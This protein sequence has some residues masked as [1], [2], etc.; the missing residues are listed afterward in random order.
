MV[1]YTKPPKKW[2]K[3]ESARQRG[4]GD[5]IKFVDLRFEKSAAQLTVNEVEMLLHILQECFNHWS[6]ELCIVYM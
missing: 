6:S 3:E 1:G 2:K 4:E 5:Q